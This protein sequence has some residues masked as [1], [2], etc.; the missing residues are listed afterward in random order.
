MIVSPK[1]IKPVGLPM[2]LTRA[3]YDD[4]SGELSFPVQGIN[5]P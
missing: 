4:L 2:E 1:M 5:S 3:H